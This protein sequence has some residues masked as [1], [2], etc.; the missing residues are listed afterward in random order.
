MVKLLIINGLGWLVLHFGISLGLLYVPD[1]LFQNTHPLNR[2]F[3]E[4]AFE[5]KGL[6]WKKY[7]AV[8]RWKDR[9]PDGASLFNL[10][11]KKK[12]LPEK[13][14]EEVNRFIKETKRAELTHWLL[15]LSGPFFFFWN[16]VWAG[17]VNVIYASLLN[18]PFIIIQRYNRARLN[19]I[20]IVMKNRR[21]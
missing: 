6:F 16:P 17:W 1:T 3:R 7:L 18:L 5:E 2:V 4:R 12:V 10:G 8:H 13:S 14:V 21:K 20:Q 19:S 15:F 11:Y 9:L